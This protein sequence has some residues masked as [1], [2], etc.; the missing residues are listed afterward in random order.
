MDLTSIV[1]C[2]HLKCFYRHH[3]TEYFFFFQDFVSY[4]TVLML[5]GALMLLWRLISLQ[6][7]EGNNSLSCLIH[8][9][10]QLSAFNICLSRLRFLEAESD[11]YRYYL[12]KFCNH[13]ITKKIIP[14]SWD[15]GSFS[16]D[17][18]INLCIITG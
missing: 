7:P 10:T 8:F 18:R 14:L 6:T 3:T 12:F 16:H 1:S 17:N 5:H 11:H 2:P 13:E 4:K 9:W 15:N